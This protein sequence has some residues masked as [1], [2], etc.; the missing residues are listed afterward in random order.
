MAGVTKHYLAKLRILEL[1][2]QQADRFVA[3][4]VS[5]PLEGH[6]A[7]ELD[8]LQ[9]MLDLSKMSPW[10]QV[11]WYDSHKEDGTVTVHR[12]M[13]RHAR[14]ALV[15]S[16][17]FKAQELLREVGLEL[18][19]RDSFYVVLEQHRDIHHTLSA[20]Y[21]LVYARQQNKLRKIPVLP[22]PLTK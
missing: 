18:T 20:T 3:S 17:V 2:V 9:R 19:V 8:E 21:L 4:I 5:V 13:K 16:R 14:D 22:R 11:A 10:R 6:Q 1:L 15:K 7:S 12:K